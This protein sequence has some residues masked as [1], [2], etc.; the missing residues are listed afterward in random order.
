[1]LISWSRRENPASHS[2]WAAVPLAVSSIDYLKANTGALHQA[3]PFDLVIVDEAHHVARS[4]AGQS[5]TASTER[6]RVARLLAG[7]T[8]ELLLLSATP[9]NGYPES[10]A[11]LLQLLEPYLAADDGRLDPTVLEP[12]MCFHLIPDLKVVHQGGVVFSESIVVTER[13]HEPLT[14]FPQ[15]IFFR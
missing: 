2:P 3:P 14:D 7:R 1:M 11:S 13:G 12:R 10:F 4:F 6:S 5:R 15:E 8:R 9:H